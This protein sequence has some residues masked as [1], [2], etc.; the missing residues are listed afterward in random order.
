MKSIKTPGAQKYVYNNKELKKHQIEVMVLSKVDTFGQ[1]FPDE[2][3]SAEPAF[4][5]G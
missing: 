1:A 2:L 5:D 3:N 4:N